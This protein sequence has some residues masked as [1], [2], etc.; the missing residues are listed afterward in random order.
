[1]D[2]LFGI[3]GHKTVAKIF[4]YEVLLSQSFQMGKELYFAK[5]REKNLHQLLTCLLIP[6]TKF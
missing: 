6:Y 4:W 1:M 5:E 3:Y 2:I